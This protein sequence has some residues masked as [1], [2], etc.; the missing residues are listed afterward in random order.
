MSVKFIEI[1]INDKFLFCVMPK[2][3]LKIEI[4]FKISTTV[5]IPMN[6]DLITE[7]GNILVQDIYQGIFAEQDK[8]CAAQ[9]T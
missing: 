4:V 7:S 1:T 8:K 2:M 3:Q 5:D 6:I 9:H